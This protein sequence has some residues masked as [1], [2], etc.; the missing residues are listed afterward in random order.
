MGN[1]KTR[2]TETHLQALK[3]LEEGNLNFNEI[4]EKCGWSRDFFYYLRSGNIEK[5]GYIADVFQKEWKQIEVKRDSAI[6]ALV[7]E[8]SLL[9]QDLIRT[10]LTELKSKSRR[11]LDEKKLL[12]TLT[13]ALSKC[14]PSVSVGSLSLSY[15]KG[16]TPEEMI[17]E[18]KR[19]KTIAESSFDRRGVS[20]AASG[21]S[22]DISASNESGD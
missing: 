16:Y 4:A 8:N 6:K 12:G 14:T 13:N 18:F 21:G 2:L 10:T 9:A 17:H 11:T 15:T 3:L 1:Q 19:L 5:C 22:G 7:K 20:E